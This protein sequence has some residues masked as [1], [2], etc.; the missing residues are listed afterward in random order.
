MISKEKNILVIVDLFKS[1]KSTISSH[2]KI[3]KINKI[4]DKGIFDNIV[5]VS[6]VNKGSSLKCVTFAHLSTK[7]D[8]LFPKKDNYFYYQFDK[9]LSFYSQEFIDLIKKLNENKMPKKIF[10]IGNNFTRSIF[11]SVLDLFVSSDI[12]PFVLTRY[13][14]HSKGWRHKDKLSLKVL[15]EIIGDIYFLKDDV[16]SKRFAKNWLNNS[17][18]I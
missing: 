12:T 11:K 6:N 10:V 1:D 5:F 18:P 16:S 2:N 3:K 7:K 4:L 9:F 14:V 8:I 17:Q 15:K 13:L